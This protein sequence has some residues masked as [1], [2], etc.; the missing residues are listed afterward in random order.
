MKKTGPWLH[1][2]YYDD[3]YARQTDRDLIHWVACDDEVRI[4]FRAIGLP[5]R[6]KR[7]RVIIESNEKGDWTV[8][9]EY[10]DWSSRRRSK[11]WLTNFLIDRIGFSNLL[12][13]R[14]NAIVE[15]EE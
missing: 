2:C 1:Y 9:G 11:R 14:Y 10:A 7:F 15:Y 8:L 4:F 3:G 6:V 13:G 12:D 5:R